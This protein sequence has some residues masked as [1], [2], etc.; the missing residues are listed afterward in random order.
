MLKSCLL[1][2]AHLGIGSTFLQF[3]LQNK[4]GAA[5]NMAI[6]K[7][8]M[9]KQK[10]CLGSHFQR[11]QTRLFIRDSVASLHCMIHMGHM[12]H[13]TR[14]GA[15][16]HGTSCASHGHDGASS[17]LCNSILV[18]S[19][20]SAKGD[21]LVVLQKL[22]QKFFGCEN[23]IVHLVGLNLNTTQLGIMFEGQLAP[24]GV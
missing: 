19:I 23:G 21:A 1:Q 13:E 18:S 10:S 3:R 5:P 22:L 8:A 7:D 2:G 15:L 16:Q 24:D 4:H 12:S 20:N 9:S 6:G 11:G 14:S 17:F